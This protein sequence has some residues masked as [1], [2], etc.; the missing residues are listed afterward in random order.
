MMDDLE[1]AMRYAGQEDRPIKG[2]SRLFQQLRSAAKYEDPA[3][4]DDMLSAGQRL[5]KQG[6]VVDAYWQ[7]FAKAAA[8]RGIP[9]EELRK[10]RTVRK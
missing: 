1:G 3:G 2:M 4:L 6:S 7:G 10:L 9:A 5:L 8:A